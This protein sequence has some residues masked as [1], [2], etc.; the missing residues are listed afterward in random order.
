MADAHTLIFI[1]TYNESANVEP[2][3]RQIAGLG[4]EA[5]MLFIDDNSPDGTGA[6]LDRLAQGDS[7]VR[8]VHRPAKMGIGSAHQAGIAWA[9]ARG[10]TTL[11]TM[12]SDFAHSPQSIA[13]LLAQA[14]RADVV[15]ASRFLQPDSL[16][17]WNVLRKFPDAHRA[18]HDADLA[19]YALRRHRGLPPVQP[20]PDPA[21]AVSA[22][23][24]QGYSFFFES[25]FILLNNGYTIR[26]IPVV[27]PSRV[28]GE[29][30][31]RFTDAWKKPAPAVR[32]LVVACPATAALP[33]AP[34][35]RP[36]HENPAIPRPAGLGCILAERARG[37]VT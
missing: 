30:K 12:D 26:E 9:Y 8:V 29:S 23:G 21:R 35:I 6:I 15:V 22:R 5:D 17:D 14:G 32:D 1:P 11:I 33:G 16:K 19:E 10:Y 7:R 36:I 24:S 18:F 13:V 37:F 20:G 3:Y 34:P 25:L 27:L 28:Y 31:M 2:L 4:L